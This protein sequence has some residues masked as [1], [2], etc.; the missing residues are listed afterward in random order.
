MPPVS[1]P[2]IDAHP[3]TWLA[4]LRWTHR[5]HAIRIMTFDT[6]SAPPSE[7]EMGSHL[8]RLA[9]PFVLAIP[10]MVG[11]L[12]P[13]ALYGERSREVAADADRALV[14]S[15]APTVDGA[16]VSLDPQMLCDPADADSLD[17][18][19]SELDLS[20]DNHKASVSGL[21]FDTVNVDVKGLVQGSPG[22]KNDITIRLER[23][24]RGWCV[25]DVETAIT[26]PG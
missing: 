10:L 5:G 24:S 15:L 17:T 20:G 14:G 21:G 9:R 18:T 26:Q 1:R 23:A 12:L 2:P 11:T 8:S 22:P 19:F 3:G 25:V 7:N 16:A 6:E 4:N 13:A